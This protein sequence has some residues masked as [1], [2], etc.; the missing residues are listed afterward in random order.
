MVESTLE[1]PIGFMV[2]DMQNDHLNR[3]VLYNAEIEDAVAAVIQKHVRLLEAARASNIKI[4]Y[5]GHFLRADYADAAPGGKASRVGTLQDGSPG[6]AIVDELAPQEGDY[7]IRKGGGMSAFT[8]SILDK[9]LR[10]AGIRTLVVAGVATHVGVESTVRSASDL[11]YRCIVVEDACRSDL[12]ENHEA[13]ILN[14][15]GKFAQIM[16]TDQTISLFMS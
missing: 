1:G 3:G 2:H 10:R 8:G 7:L 16:S 13:S 4:F 14:M 12:I 11:D 9:M 5:V 15:D 6:A